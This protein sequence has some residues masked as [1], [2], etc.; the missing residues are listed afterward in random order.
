MTRSRLLFTGTLALVILIVYALSGCMDVPDFCPKIQARPVVT[1]EPAT[2]L[3]PKS[4]PA[5]ILTPTTEVLDY[6][7]EIALGAEFGDQTPVIRKWSSGPRIQV[8]GNPTAVDLITLAQVISE[9]NELVGGLKLELV[10][11][12]ANLDIHF[13]P[14]SE[15]PSI[16]K[17]Y[18]P[19]NAGYFWTCWS[20]SSVIYKAIILIAS[21]RTE[22][23]RSHLI[24]EELTQALGLMRD[25]NFRPES[26]FYRQWSTVT[27]YSDI[28]R[29]VIRILYLED[30][31]V[32][33]TRD[34]VL[35]LFAVAD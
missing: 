34:D 13:K 35:A 30:V 28:D 9:L 11:D 14:Q 3:T 16:L 6:F 17:E 25:S 15:F 7:L 32:G 2:T 29:E 24:R 33:M 18:E 26:T 8:H 10:Q 4:E 19:G 5:T 23:V 27:E 31:A 1:P 22:E 21:D 20:S 12:N